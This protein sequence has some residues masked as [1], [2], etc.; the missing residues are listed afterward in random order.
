MAAKFPATVMVL[1]FISIKKDVTP[2]SFIKGLKIDTDEYSKGASR[3][4][5]TTDGQIDFWMPLGLLAVWYPCPQL[6]DDS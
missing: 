5:E 2:P 4:S 3:R 1:G 6:Q